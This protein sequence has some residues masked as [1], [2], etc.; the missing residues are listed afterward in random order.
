MVEKVC[1][2]CG[3]SLP[4]NKA[5]RPSDYCSTGCRRAAEFE[6]RRVN[7]RLESLETSLSSMRI[8]PDDELMSMI[9]GCTRTERVAAVEAE[10]AMLKAR[11]RELL[12][13]GGLA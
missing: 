6:I 11:F 13:D 7:R 8:N 3:V 5:R 2:S 10:L 12:D 4:V 1:K 9:A